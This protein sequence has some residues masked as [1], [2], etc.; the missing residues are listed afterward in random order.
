LEQKRRV[1]KHLQLGTSFPRR[2]PASH[3]TPAA[4]RLR[5]DAFVQAGIVAELVERPRGVS[6]EAFAQQLID[7]ERL[8]PWNVEQMSSASAQGSMGSKA[9]FSC[10]GRAII[11]EIM[12]GDAQRTGRACRL[13][14]AG[15]PDRLLPPRR[16][17]REKEWNTRL[18]NPAIARA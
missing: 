17:G 12:G 2:T 16:C 11:V 3:E 10:D 14:L 8:R 1:G 4:A 7:A 15:G 13:E 5:G 6:D 18:R 9:M